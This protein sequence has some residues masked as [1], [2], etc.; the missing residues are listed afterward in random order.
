MRRFHFEVEDL[1]DELP[2]PGFYKARVCAARFRIRAS[3]DRVLRVEFALEHVP[4]RFERVAEY[5][6]LEGDSS[7]QIRLARRALAE[8]YRACGR[9]PQAGDIISPAHLRGAGLEVEIEHEH[10]DEWP[11]IHVVGHRFNTDRAPF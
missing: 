8:L 5:F 1:H 10:Y 9:S 3:G 6:A 4:S 2:P 11:R 7:H